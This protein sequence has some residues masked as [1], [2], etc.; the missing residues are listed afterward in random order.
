MSGDGKPMYAMSHPTITP[1][2]ETVS[3]LEGHVIVENHDTG[4]YED[5]ESAADYVAFYVDKMKA[6]GCSHQ[7]ISGFKRKWR[8]RL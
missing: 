8:K 6:A 4:Q 3:K 5:F 1:M 7:R 2:S